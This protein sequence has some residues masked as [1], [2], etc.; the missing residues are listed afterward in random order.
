MK[1]I[2]KPLIII[3]VVIFL[4]ALCFY[5][6]AYFKLR[7]IKMDTLKNNI[8]AISTS[9]KPVQIMNEEEKATLGLNKR[10]NFE[11]ISRDSA[12]KIMTY[13]FAGMKEAQPIQLEWMSDDEKIKKNI[14][15]STKCQVLDRDNNGEITAYKVIQNDSDIIS[16]Y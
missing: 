9:N 4:L 2:I 12:G 16:K 11:V 10:A 15:T 1:K 8:T 13:K 6:G 14:S 7:S 5:L 3:I